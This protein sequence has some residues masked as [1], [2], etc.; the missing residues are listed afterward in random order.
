MTA[1]KLFFSSAVLLFA[2]AS[3]SVQPDDVDVAVVGK[4]V[5]DDRI[6]FNEPTLTWGPWSEWSIC[7]RTCG[8]GTQQRTRTCDDQG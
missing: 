1:F 2:F 4:V 6:Q 3:A 5:P 8:N 7:S